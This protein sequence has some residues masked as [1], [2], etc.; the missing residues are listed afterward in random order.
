MCD[1]TVRLNPKL[2]RPD[3]DD[4]IVHGNHEVGLCIRMGR[5]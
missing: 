1:A 4:V 2:L 5:A 3:R